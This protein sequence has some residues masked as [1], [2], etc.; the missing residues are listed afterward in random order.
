[1]A[2]EVVENALVVVDVAMVV[3]AAVAVV[4]TVMVALTAQKMERNMEYKMFR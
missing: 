3:L 1:M 2:V 4:V